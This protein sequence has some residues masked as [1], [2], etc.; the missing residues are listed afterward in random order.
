MSAPT[1]RNDAFALA[2]EPATDGENLWPP[3]S[4]NA[5]L[6]AFVRL[7][8]CNAPD[9]PIPWGDPVIV[10]LF[11][12]AIPYLNAEVDGVRRDREVACCPWPDRCADGE[13]ELRP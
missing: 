7:A 2:T 11:E 8:Q 10:E 6:D 13:C 5:A 9:V 1:G 12:A 3:G 4:L